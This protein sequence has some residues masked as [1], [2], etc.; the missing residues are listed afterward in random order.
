IWKMSS[1]QD[2]R[3][4]ILDALRAGRAPKEIIEFLK[5]PKTTVYRVAQEFNES[6]GNATPLRKTQDRSRS[7]KRTLEFFHELQKRI[8]DD[9]G[10]SMRDLAAK[11]NADEKNIRTAVHEDLRSKSYVLKVRQMLSEASK[12]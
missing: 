10:T 12:A 8:N 11:I 7:K 2:R 3:A 9:P 4:A 1:E 5:L 6:N